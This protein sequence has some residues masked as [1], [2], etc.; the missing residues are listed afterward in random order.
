M[1]ENLIQEKL[2][3]GSNLDPF[4]LLKVKLKVLQHLDYGGTRMAS[5]T[6]EKSEFLSTYLKQ[7]DMKVIGRTPR[8]NA[9]LTGSL[10]CL[11]MKTLGYLLE[12][13]NK[14]IRIESLLTL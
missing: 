5:A 3:T 10:C 8:K 12:D 2:R 6:G 1:I 13:S 11:R 9:G 7:R 14:L 4:Q